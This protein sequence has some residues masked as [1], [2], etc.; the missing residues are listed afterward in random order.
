MKSK[1]DAVE[2]PF[3]FTDKAKARDALG[4]PSGFDGFGPLAAC[5]PPLSG[6]FGEHVGG[7]LF[8]GRLCHSG[9]PEL[10]DHLGVSL[11]REPPK[12]TVFLVVSLENQQ[13]ERGISEESSKKVLCLGMPQKRILVVRL[14]SLCH[15]SR[16]G[17]F[18]QK[19][20]DNPTNRGTPPQVRPRLM[21]VFL[22]IMGL[23]GMCRSK[24]FH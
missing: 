3:N 5:F 6:N 15:T 13:L 19:A 23:Q 4:G 10:L 8:L 11:N 1:F 17:L 9:L 12:M 20:G 21:C 2:L 14:V 18:F 22:S 7:G 24:A 16:K